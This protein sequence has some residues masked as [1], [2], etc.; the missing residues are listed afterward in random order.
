MKEDRKS[1]ALIREQVMKFSTKIATG[2][3]K[4][5]QK[6]VAQMVFGIL[7]A[8][9]IKFS[10]IARSLQEEIRLIK[11]ETRLSRNAKA[12]GV[13]KNVTEALIQ[14]GAVWI[15]NDTVLAIDISDIAK[16]YAEKME[17]LA[18]VRDGSKGELTKGYWL[19]GVVGA[20]VNGERLTPLR[21][22]LYSQ[23]ADDFDSENTQILNAIDQVR[24]A[25]GTRGIW[26]IDRGGDRGTLLDGLLSRKAR[27][28]I[29]LIG[30]RNL[31]D[32][33]GR[34]RNSLT[35]ACGMRC[36]ETLEF[37]TDEQGVNRR[38]TVRVGYRTVRLPKREEQL[39]L[40]V[41][42]GFGEKP[43]L[44]LTSANDKPAR[45]I[46]EIY[47][48]RWKIEESFRVLKSGYHVED[49]RAR[50]Y[51]RLRNVVVLLMAAFYFLAAVL[52][53]RFELRI[54]LQKIL[55]KARRFFETP[56]F[57]FYALAD[58]LFQ[59]LF[60]IGFQQLK[61]PRFVRPNQL[62]LSFFS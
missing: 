12:K 8:S 4:P 6:F 17:Y 50:S 60:R 7:A 5:L 35:L 53:E 9:D 46:L 41:I 59:M 61:K 14:E 52:G 43:M 34:I 21:M 62:T 45:G 13:A 20:D 1:P 22:E 16:E 56:A 11:T 18:T 55:K 24:S 29:R 58:G 47:L 28:V 19:I 36:R 54:L 2:L 25:L 48:T 37:V 40:V 57:K 38:R 31:R 51:A 33:R 15:K 49:I 30:Q 3:S 23:E 27:F 39:T 32:E 26:A 10:N 44:L 42:K